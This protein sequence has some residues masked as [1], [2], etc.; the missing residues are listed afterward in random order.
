[1]KDVETLHLYRCIGKNIFSYRKK[2]GFSQQD[3]ADRIQMSRVSVV[4]IEK[5]RQH[6]PIH[7]LFKISKL[8]NVDII[9]LLKVDD[10]NK[11]RFQDDLE[12]EVKRGVIGIKKV[13]GS[14][15]DSK[16]ILNFLTE[17]S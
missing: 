14:E 16:K 6:P 1:M 17:N 13:T 2:L 7:L 9:E 12:K 8:L 3:L 5:G 15:I 4:N 11:N 10:F